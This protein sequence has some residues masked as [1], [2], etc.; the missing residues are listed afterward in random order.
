MSLAP[1]T[2]RINVPFIVRVHNTAPQ[3]HFRIAN[4]HNTRCTPRIV[5]IQHNYDVSVFSDCHLHRQIH[6][7]PIQ[8]AREAPLDAGSDSRSYICAD[9]NPASR[10][11]KCKCNP[12][13]CAVN[14][15]LMQSKHRIELTLPPAVSAVHSPCLCSVCH[16]FGICPQASTVIVTGAAGSQK[17]EL[18]EL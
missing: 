8:L 10:S 9:H 14:N 12:T 18:F 17:E 13:T 16:P 7:A 4:S 3:R 11:N 1:D 5:L 2:C 6:Q 15:R